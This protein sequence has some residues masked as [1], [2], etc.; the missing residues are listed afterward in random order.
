MKKNKL[1]IITI[2][3]LIVLIVMVSVV[4]IYK[5]NQNKM[6]NQVKDYQYSMDLTGKRVLSLKLDTGTETV[7]KDKDGNKIESATDEEIQQ[8]GYTKEEVKKNKN[9]DLTKDNYR[10]AKK[11]IQGRLDSLNKKIVQNHNI[12][13]DLEFDKI[14]VADYEVRLNEA[15][16]EVTVEIPDSDYADSIISNLSTV[17]KFEIVDEES[18]D[19]LL[20]NENIS[21]CQ[22]ESVPTASG[23]VVYVAIQFNNDGKKKLEEISNI[24]VPASTDTEDESEEQSEDETKTT[25]ETGEEN[26]EE[27]KEKKVSM[28]I[29]G[30]EQMS[31]S[32]KEPVTDG[33]IYLSIGKAS[34]DRQ[35]IK[36]NIRN[37]QNIAS[38]LDNKAMP[39]EYEVADSNYVVATIENATN[40]ILIGVAVLTVIALVIFVVKFRTMGLLAIIADVGLAGLLLLIVRYWNV[41]ISFE[42]IVSLYSILLLNFVLSYKMLKNI[43]KDDQKEEVKVLINKTIKD[44]SLKIIPLFILSIVLTFSQR[45]PAN[46]FGKVMFWGL[47]LIEIYNLL[48]TKN[49]LKYGKDK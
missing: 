37:A 3:A 30:Q 49:L 44:I 16:G 48:I 29:D 22:V 18:K 13:N 8:N 17:G 25:G 47:V 20:N 5:Q 34:T 10:N 11:I 42:G 38:L 32:F 43:S 14:N 40:V 19:V 27:Q 23:T 4:G 7:I 1:K 33:K 39:L 31:T 35:T 45:T 26:K 46:S 2:T 21:S 15:N 9:E 28:Q 12:N 36:E 41:V 6:E 24:Y